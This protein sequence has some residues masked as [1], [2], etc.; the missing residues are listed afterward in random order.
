MDPQDAVKQYVHAWTLTDEADIRSALA[1]CWADDAS[2]TDPSTDPVVGVEGLTRHILGFAEQFP[3]ATMAPT[4]GLDAHH[5]V[6]RFTWLLSSPTSLV[7]DGVDLG[8]ALPGLDFV[9]F[10]EDGRIQRVVGFFG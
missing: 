9:E 4:S 3:D 10:A 6:G 7:A 5:G 8:P 2:Y 1:G